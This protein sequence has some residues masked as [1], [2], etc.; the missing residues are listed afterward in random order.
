MAGTHCLVNN[1]RL[2]SLLALVLL[3]TTGR[4]AN[5]YFDTTNASGL[6]PGTATWDVGATPVWATTNNPGVT[7]PGLWSN[8]NDAFFQ[9][10]GGNTVTISGSIQTNTLTQATNG[11]TTTFTGGTLQ[12]GNGTTA[13]LTN[14]GNS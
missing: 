12:I 4:A 7:A 10:A 11:T 1:P 6:T 5:L 3:A 2:I 9:T 8:G 13:T 14:S